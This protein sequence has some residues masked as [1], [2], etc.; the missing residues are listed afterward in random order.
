MD[1]RQF[2]SNIFYLD[3]VYPAFLSNV[4]IS[5]TENTNDD[6]K[7]YDIFDDF[8]VTF[9]FVVYNEA[10]YKEFYRKFVR[11]CTD[12]KADLSS[13]CYEM[14]EHP[15]WEINIAEWK[16]FCK[17]FELKEFFGGYMDV[18]VDDSTIPTVWHICDSHYYESD[19]ED[20]EEYDYDSIFKDY[21][22]QSEEEPLFYDY[23]NEAIRD[24]LTH[25]LD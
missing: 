24:G 2:K 5:F 13:F 4:I 7:S 22:Y 8:D 19:D 9:V 17:S 11:V 6:K 15:Y 25:L 16:E 23:I 1:N 21:E 18:I 12:G 20:D 3:D 10:G 14:I